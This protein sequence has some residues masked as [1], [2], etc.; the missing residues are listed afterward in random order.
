MEH[1]VTV[2]LVDVTKYYE[3]KCLFRNISKKLLPG[4][5]LTVTGPNGSGKSTLLKIISGLVKTS[6]GK[7]NLR[8]NANRLIS[9]CERAKY[10]GFVSPELVFYKS[11]TGYEN[12]DF[13]AKA[14]G[15]AALPEFIMASLQ[16]VGLSGQAHEPVINYSTGMRQRLKFALLLVLNPPLWLLDE[17]SSNLDTAGKKLVADLIH[18]A[19]TRSTSIILAT[20]EAEEAN[21][22]HQKINLA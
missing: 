18:K 10:I 21:Y 11:L 6:S 15:M 20:N 16:R 3:N 22:A 13:I 19:L 1:S 8:C 17:P 2:E 4:E 12:I 7:I 9:P 5:C 14:S